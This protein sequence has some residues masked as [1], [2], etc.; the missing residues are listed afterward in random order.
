MDS[1]QTL[2]GALVTAPKATEVLSTRTGR[3]PEGA[4]VTV[5]E[6]L[7]PAGGA[8]PA[9][10][11]RP[12]GIPRW[13]SGSC[14]AAVPGAEARG[15]LTS[16][17]R[18]Q[19]SSG[20]TASLGRGAGNATQK[21]VMGA[22]WTPRPARPAPPSGPCGPGRSDTCSAARHFLSGA[23]TCAGSARRLSIGS[24]SS[25]ARLRG[26]RR[27]SLRLPPPTKTLRPSSPAR[28]F[29]TTNPSAPKP[30]THTRRGP[31]ARPRQP[32]LYSHA[33]TSRTRTGRRR[34]P[35]LSPESGPVI[36]HKLESRS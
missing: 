20:S 22:G 21:S 16:G 17:N 3:V 15:G 12:A 33:E 32:C 4:I 24:R 36:G 10:S 11:V 25:G 5:P 18:L 35:G 6:A 14:D 13:I 34:R 2:T 19:S 27:A 1:T 31:T 8:A 9:G 26:S 7:T 23:H 29:K 30:P 28:N